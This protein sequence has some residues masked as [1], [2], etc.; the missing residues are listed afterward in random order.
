LEPLFVG[1]NI[2]QMKSSGS[3]QSDDTKNASKDNN[4]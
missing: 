3:D 1:L 4:A 2:V